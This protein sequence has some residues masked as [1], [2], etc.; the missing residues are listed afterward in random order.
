MC[1]TVLLRKF[2]QMKKSVKIDV[3]MD[4]LGK[5]GNVN[6][7]VSYLKSLTEKNV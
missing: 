2:S 6:L 4:L 7:S 3:I 5:M 1:L